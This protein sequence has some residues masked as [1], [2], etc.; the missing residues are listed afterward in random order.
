ML[1][2]NAGIHRD[3]RNLQTYLEKVD[4]PSFVDGE[5]Q[6]CVTRDALVL[7]IRDSGKFVKWTVSEIEKLRPASQ[8]AA[9]SAR[10][11]PT[12]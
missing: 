9:K 6:F 1:A 11:P 12:S 5:G 8:A 4:K 10:K 7:I 3:K 2:R